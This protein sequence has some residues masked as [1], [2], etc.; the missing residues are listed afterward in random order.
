MTAINSR[1]AITTVQGV[2]EYVSSFVGGA[3]PQVGTDEYNELIR[4]IQ[5]GQQDMAHRGF[6]RRLL[7]KA[8]LSIVEDAETTT[9]PTNFYKVNGIFA[10]IV[11]E[12]D[13]NEP[14]NEDEVR[15][16][17]EVHPTTG[18][19]RI[20]WL[21]DGAIKTATG[22]LWY[23]FNPPVIQAAADNII[24]DGEAMG[25]YVLKE[26]YRK[27]KQFG[28]LDD[29]RIEYENRVNN[30]LSAEMLPS[31]QEMTNFRSYGSQ[32]GIS[33]RG[34]AIYTGRGSRGR[35]F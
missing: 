34:R 18:A 32:Q 14:A 5:L 9:L 3:I 4:W 13:W 8:D 22:D 26:Y 27:L 7:T 30:L 17:V 35:S 2:L 23:F 25:F 16:F 10:L 6:W 12:V 20:R 19:W 31:K 15:I 33:S 24:L 29:A 1:S 21:P 28:S 11:D